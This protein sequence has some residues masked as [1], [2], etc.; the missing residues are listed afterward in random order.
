MESNSHRVSSS[1]QPEGYSSD[2]SSAA[3]SLRVDACARDI[4][5]L[6]NA[7]DLVLS[8]S[9]QT[10]PLAARVA[11]LANVRALLVDRGNESTSR[12]R[13]SDGALLVETL[14]AARRVAQSAGRV[15]ILLRAGIDSTA[16][17]DDV[18]PPNGHGT[19][20]VCVTYDKHSELCE[21]VEQ[22]AA[23]GLAPWI[24]LG[25]GSALLCVPRATLESPTGDSVSLL[26]CFVPLATTDI[27]RQ[28]HELLRLQRAH[29]ERTAVLLDELLVHHRRIEAEL[30]DLRLGSP[31][32]VRSEAPVTESRRTPSAVRKARKLLRDPR[33]FFNDSK[34]PILRVVGTY[35]R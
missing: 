34:H 29:E 16:L 8:L 18:A 23:R 1:E 5:A 25:A 10:A 26:P 19:P 20:D 30:F 15:L 4:A 17:L 28:L 14:A 13:V 3:G 27:S 12:P 7:K 33:S 11:E 2:S 31:A 6:V 21:V 22:L 24:H 35:L 9:S 32:K